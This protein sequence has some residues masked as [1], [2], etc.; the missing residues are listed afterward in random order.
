MPARWVAPRAG[1]RAAR[2]ADVQH[3]PEWLAQQRDLRVVAQAPVV[4]PAPAY[5][6]EARHSGLAI[7]AI[8]ST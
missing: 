5:E 6:L 8:S 3:A 1:V 7:K 2:A 4:V